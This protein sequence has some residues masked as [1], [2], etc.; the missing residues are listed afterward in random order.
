VTFDLNEHMAAELY[1]STYKELPGNIFDR[2]P[3]INPLVVLPDPWPVR[4]Q[5]SEGLVR[6]FFI[7]GFNQL[8][9]RQTYTDE[10]IEG[11]GLMFVIDLLDDETGEVRHQTYIRLQIPTGLDKFTLG[12]AVD[13]AGKRA[14]ARWS[15]TPEEK[16]VLDLFTTLLKPALSILV[17][18][19]CDNRDVVEPPVVKPTR[20]KRKKPAQRDRDPFFVEVGWRVGPRLHAARRAAG[21]VLDGNGVPSGV[22]RAPHQR[23][24]HFHKYLV[25][26]KRTQEITLFVEP[27]WVNFHLLPEDVDPI[28]TVV[29]VDPQRHDPL[30]RRGLRGRGG[31]SS[32]PSK[33]S[34]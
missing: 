7:H 10:E 5:Q 2:L 1:R 23:A 33:C 25:G 18:L 26:P 11:L 6:G 30:R 20:K 4:Y 28:T 17:Y 9:E 27:H 29:T 12:Q 32:K 16:P 21:R 24:G 34:V 13:F 31:K 14:E 22:Q 19:C 8:P 15:R 3:Y